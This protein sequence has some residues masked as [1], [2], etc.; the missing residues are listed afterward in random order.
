MTHLPDT[1]AYSAD[2]EAAHLAQVFPLFFKPNAHDYSFIWPFNASK[3][4][5]LNPEAGTKARVKVD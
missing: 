2:I 1:A 4:V 3:R 5:S